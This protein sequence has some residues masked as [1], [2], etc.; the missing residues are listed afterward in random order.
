MSYGQPKL[1]VSP[2]EWQ[3]L[4]AAVGLIL[5]WFP[6]WK[7]FGPGAPYAKLE[8]MGMLEEFLKGYKE[9]IYK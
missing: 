3:R 4:I 2:A 6:E 8:E 7:P 1:I 5:K 9:G